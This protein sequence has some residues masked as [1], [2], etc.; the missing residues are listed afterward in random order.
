[1]GKALV[2]FFHIIVEINRIDKSVHQCLPLLL[3]AHVQ[4][5]EAEQ[6]SQSNFSIVY[7]IIGLH[8]AK[9]TDIYKLKKFQGP[10][11]LFTLLFRL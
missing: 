9:Y 4:L 2:T 11:N 3:L 6:T 1:M 8:I 10:L 5:A 7:N